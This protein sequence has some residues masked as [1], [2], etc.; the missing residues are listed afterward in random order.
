MIQSAQ[1]VHK[2]LVD[3][4]STREACM[5]LLILACRKSG[6][7][8][9][10]IF[11]CAYDYYE[12]RVDSEEM[13]YYFRSCCVRDDRNKL[14]VSLVPKFVEDFCLDLMAGKT[15]LPTKQEMIAMK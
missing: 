10:Q 13:E 3:K 14:M 4:I 2:R 15:T 12:M 9:A 7:N 11:K 8:P 1:I 5:K 6:L